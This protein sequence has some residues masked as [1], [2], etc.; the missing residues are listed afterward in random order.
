MEKKDLLAIICAVGIVII[1]I[2]VLGMVK[3]TQTPQNNSIPD[4]PASTEP[5]VLIEKTDVWDS[6]RQMQTTAAVTG[7]TG[8]AAVTGDV[9]DMQSSGETQSTA[10]TLP[11]ET[12]DLPAESDVTQADEL[13]AVTGSFTELP[14]SETTATESIVPYEFVLTGIGGIG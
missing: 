1:V 8:E 2:G 3:G 7:L 4:L 5:I 11:A 9:T 12:D 13:P 6:I 14:A 10:L